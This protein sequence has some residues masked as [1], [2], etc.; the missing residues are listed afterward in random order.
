M[1]LKHLQLMLIL[2]VLLVVGGIEWQQYVAGKRALAELYTIRLKSLMHDKSNLIRKEIESSRE[3]VPVSLRSLINTTKILHDFVKEAGMANESTVTYSTDKKEI[4]HAFEHPPVM[5]DAFSPEMFFSKRNVGIQVVHFIDGTKRFDTFYVTLNPYALKKEFEQNFLRGNL[6]MMIIILT[7]LLIYIAIIHNLVL[8]PINRLS[9]ALQKP[10]ESLKALP[11]LFLSELQYLKERF[12]ATMDDIKSQ[13]ELFR[14]LFESAPDAIVLLDIETNSIALYNRQALAMLGY[15]DSEFRSL[16]VFDITTMA[17]EKFNAKTAETKQ[18]IYATYEDR[19]KKRNGELIDVRVIRR[20]LPMNGKEYCLCIWHNVTEEHKELKRR[21][22]A[23]SVLENTQEAIMILGADRKIISVNRAF[24]S[25][26]GYAP[27]E[28]MGRDPHMLSSSKHTKAFYQ[29]LYGRL[30]HNGHWSGEIID[31]KKSGEV[32]SLWANLTAVKDERGT[33]INY[34]A[35]Y[36]DISELKAVREHLEYLSRHD[37]LTGLIN[38][39]TFDLVLEHAMVQ[40]KQHRSQFAVLLIDID[41]FK[42]INDTYGHSAGD[43]FLV[44]VANILQ[45]LIPTGNEIARVGGD[46]FIISF[47]EIDNIPF[48]LDQLYNRCATPI[49]VQENHY[50]VSLS[51]GVAIFP[52]DGTTVDALVKNADAAMYKAKN[53]GKNRYMF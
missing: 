15:K 28:V 14:T 13:E 1:R 52:Q 36:S 31:R 22:L 27:E 4:G 23:S 2:L 7:F 17:P 29:N 6:M 24:V 10:G 44:Q 45:K 47:Q 41:D 37:T 32:V 8:Q 11:P 35:V 30:E 40:A 49:H 38:K 12:T 3:E 39:N 53:S 33:L 43:Q 21:L 16:S 20:Y 48:F 9:A 25:L 46:E 51:I 42:D 18:H 34:L 5:L 50:Y 26:F 19:F